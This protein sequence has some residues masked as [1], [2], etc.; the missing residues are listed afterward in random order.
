MLKLLEHI[1]EHYRLAVLLMS[2]SGMRMTEALQLRAESVDITNEVIQIWGKGGKERI[3]PIMTER[4]RTA[5][6]TRI[7]EIKK[8]QERRP[9]Y[10]DFLVM[11]PR[12]AKPYWD[13]KKPLDRASANTLHMK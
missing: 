9:K 4:L 5:L 13:I 3:V 12:T 6:V 7:A 10:E 1:E 11:N 2:D 8:K